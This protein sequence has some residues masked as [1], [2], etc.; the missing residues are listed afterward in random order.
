MRDPQR[1]HGGQSFPE[2]VAGGLQVLEDVLLAPVVVERPGQGRAKT[3][4][5]RPAFDRVDVVH[6]GMEILGVLRRVLQGDL[7]TDAFLLAGHV[8]D[9]LVQRVA[10]PI[11]MLDEL[12]DA[13][14]VQELLALIVAFVEKLDP[15]AA[16]EERQ[17][18]QPL[19]EQVVAELGRLEDHGVGLEGRLGAHLLGRADALD[20]SERNAAFVLLLVG[21]PV[22]RDF[23]FAPLRQEVHD[24]DTHAVQTAGRLVRALFE[25]PAELQDGHH[26][27][28]RRDFPP[29]FLRQLLVRFDGNAATVVLHRHGTFRIDG[30][31]DV[32]GKPR[33]GFVDRVVDDFVH[34]MVQTAR[35]DIADVHGGPLADMVHVR[36][37]LQV[38]RPVVGLR[39]LGEAL[40]LRLVCRLASRLIVTHRIVHFTTPMRKRK[41]RIFWSGNA[42]TIFSS[43][44]FF[45]KVNSCSTAELQTMTSSTPRRMLPM[46]LY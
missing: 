37:V 22:A 31:L 24:R 35:R 34:Q 21:M 13:P 39:G 3:G 12:D 14:L 2:I 26:A 15:H 40:L 33:H 23:D 30:D 28:E 1:D 43:N 36:Q 27:F 5:V 45:W 16:V 11:Q 41:S 4:H 29:E 8:D 7:V 25:L 9:F 19:V 10:G 42:T 6:I 20:R 44:C 17:F 46:R 18:L 32:L 38:L